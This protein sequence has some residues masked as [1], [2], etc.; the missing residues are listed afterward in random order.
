MKDVI[1]GL[2]KKYFEIRM[3]LKR[4]ILTE[5]KGRI[6]INVYDDIAPNL[7][8]M[9]ERDSININTGLGKPDFTMVNKLQEDER[10]R[11]ANQVLEM[12][13]TILKNNSIEGIDSIKVWN[14]KYS[15]IPPNI[16]SNHMDIISYC[17]GAMFYLGILTPYEYDIMQPAFDEGGNLLYVKNIPKPKTDEVTDA[18][19]HM[20]QEDE[21]K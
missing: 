19:G 2:I 18:L 12:T 8:N 17:L 13:L 14:T 20:V 7:W 6:T 3:I 21:E 4:T 16:K 10:Q 5:R 15:K 9:Y 11:I 1:Q